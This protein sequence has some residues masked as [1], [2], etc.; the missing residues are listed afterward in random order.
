M[1]EGP[2][3]GFDGIIHAKNGSA[4]LKVLL[5]EFLSIIGKHPYAYYKY[6][7][8]KCVSKLLLCQ[9]YS[10]IIIIIYIKG[11]LLTI[12]HKLRISTSGLLKF[13]DKLF[14]KLFA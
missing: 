6:L 10:S 7:L 3:K 4:A 13:A 14:Y 9:E 1:L 5:T 11:K 8:Q 12:Y 2:P